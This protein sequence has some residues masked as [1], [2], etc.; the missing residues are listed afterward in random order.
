MSLPPLREGA[1]LDVKSELGCFDDHRKM[2]TVWTHKF[3]GC[4]VPSVHTNCNHNEIAALLLRSLGPTP[5]PDRAGFAPVRRTFKRLRGL[6]R[7]YGGISWSFR[8]TA[9]SYHGA[10]RRRYIEAEMSLAD[11]GPLG[12]SDYLLK[13]FLKAE[14]FN[15]VA[16]FAKPRMIFPRSPRY[17]LVL[18][19]RLKPFEHWLWGRLTSRGLFGGSNTRVVAKGLNQRERAGIIRKKM[20]LIPGCVVFEVDGKA[21]EAHVDRWQLECEHAVY[22][23]AFPGDRELQAALSHQLFNAGVTAGGV[24]FSREG[25][26]ASGDFNTGMGNTIIMTVVVVAVLRHLRVPFDLLVDGDNALVFLPPWCSSRVISEF[27]ALALQFSG[28][29]MVLE[30]PVTVVEEVRFG[31]CAP[32]HLDSGWQMV[33]DW[34]KV[35]SQGTSNHKHLHDPRFVRS[36]LH[37]IALCELS[38]GADVPIVGK[39]A[40]ILRKHTE[41]GRR[42]QA[43]MYMDYVYLG[44]D[45]A[46]VEEARFKEASA[47]ARESFSR[48]FGVTPDE[49]V[50]LEGALQ[51]PV[52]PDAWLPEEPLTRDTWWDARPGL[53]E[54]FLGSR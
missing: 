54:A 51:P 28:H 18:A 38:L 44:V 20:S 15:G 13:A 43:D 33:R 2:Y 42:V 10:L 4:W 1:T 34:R 22:A 40:D 53:V 27:P 14:K 48:A 12:P 46:R 32:V 21:F 24:K 8:E 45:L 31:Q 52:F 6:A 39:W 50:A 23:S 19:S 7:R 26:R 11:D 35:L 16:K 3:D 49:Q 5:N 36:F 47:E 29:E 9:E 25:G 30:R 37:G 41:T 17:N